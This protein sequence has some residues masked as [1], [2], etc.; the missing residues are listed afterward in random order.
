MHNVAVGAFLVSASQRGGRLEPVVVKSLKGA[1]CL[2]WGEWA[3]TGPDGA[4]VQTGRDE[5]GRLRFSTSAGGV[6]VL[7]PA[8]RRI[9][10][11]GGRDGN[12]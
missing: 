10:K 7:V 1:D 3:V 2:V 5:F 6:Y 9:K 4:Q 12:D 11:G 8:E